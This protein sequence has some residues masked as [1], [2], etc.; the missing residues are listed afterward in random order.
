MWQCSTEVNIHC[1]YSLLIKILLHN[2]FLNI[3]ASS[4]EL[5]KVKQCYN[6]LMEA[7]ADLQQQLSELEV[8]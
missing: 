1:I 8:R 3:S 7:H 6:D 2:I 5:T 4:E